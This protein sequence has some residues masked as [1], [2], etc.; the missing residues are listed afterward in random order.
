MK[1]RIS[2]VLFLLIILASPELMAQVRFGIHAG[3]DLHTQAEPG[4]LW[5]NCNLYQG[6]SAGGFAEYRNKTPF[7]VQAELNFQ[8]KGEK[9]DY[10]TE[11]IKTVSNRAFNYVTLPILFKYYL[12]D[13]GLGNNWE[14][15]FMA[16]PSAGYLISAD[17][18]VKSGASISERDI[19]S[20]AKSTDFGVIFGGELQY[21]LK[22][23]H[24]IS[25]GLRYDMGLTA[26][27]NNES[28][29]RNKGAGI[30]IGYIF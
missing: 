15:S 2:S 12:K 18:R 10:E 27:D 20:E 29:N 11:G 4:E 8:K 21:N 3:A 30:T 13:T 25:A 22:G 6:F 28:G 23:G 24:G 14:I 19:T 7:S 26:I 17:S 1:T 16:G 9:A 5:N